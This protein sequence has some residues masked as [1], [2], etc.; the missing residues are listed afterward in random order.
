MWV[1]A[2]VAPL[3]E[4]P[5]DRIISCLQT[6]SNMCQFL[7]PRPAHQPSRNSSKKNHG[8]R[9]GRIG[10]DFGCVAI[11]QSGR[12]LL[13]FPL[14]APRGTGIIGM[15]ACSITPSLLPPSTRQGTFFQSTSTQSRYLPMPMNV[16]GGLSSFSGPCASYG[17]SGRGFSAELPAQMTSADCKLCVGH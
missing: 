6:R 7:S 4:P 14:L 12:G 15:T 10:G 9:P 2:T 13:A 1:A 5:T 8:R 11:V 16:F 17:W 3:P